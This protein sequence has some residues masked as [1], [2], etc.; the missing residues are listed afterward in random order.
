MNAITLLPDATAATLQASLLAVT[1]EDICR[2]LFRHALERCE[3]VFGSCS[4]RTDVSVDYDLW[5]VAVTIDVDHSSIRSTPSPAARGNSELQT[6]SHL[7]LVQVVTSSSSDETSWIWQDGRQIQSQSVIAALGTSP[8]PFASA[9]ESGRGVTVCM[10]GVFS[11]MPIRRK[12]IASEAAKK[13]SIASLVNCA[14]ELSLL[15]TDSNVR[16]R[17][18]QASPLDGPAPTAK[19]MLSLPR[20]K[21]LVYRYKSAFGADSAQLECVHLIAAE[22]T[23]QSATIKIKGFAAVTAVSDAPRFIFLQRRIWPGPTMCG[24]LP[25]S[26][27]ESAVFASLLS[28]FHL[29]WTEEASNT[30]TRRTTLSPG[31]Y[32]TVCKRIALCRTA[33]DPNGQAF[34]LDI[35]LH[36]SGRA[37]QSRGPRLSV[38]SFE[39]AVLD[40]ICKETPVAHS[41]SPGK[42]KRPSRP[43]TAG[44]CGTK[45]SEVRPVKA[46]PATASLAIESYGPKAA[47]PEGMVEWRNP[48]NGRLFH[49]DQRTGHSVAV[50]PASRMVSDKGT[51]KTVWAPATNRSTAVDRSRLNKGL[52]LSFTKRSAVVD[53]STD[54]DEFD[55][56]GLDEALASI[57]SP[58]QILAPDTFRRSRFF[59]SRLPTSPLKQGH[60]DFV[61]DDGPDPHNAVP[62]R[63]NL[64][65]AITRS[66]LQEA[67][68]LDQVDGKFIVCSTSS[69]GS[70]PNA[71]LFCIDQH[72]ADERYR[73]ER[74]LEQFASDCTE[75]TAAHALP[76]TLTLGISVK[77]CELVRG[78]TTVSEVLKRLGWSV[79]EVVLVHAALGHAQVDLD[80]IPC[81]LKDRV[82]TDRGRVKDQDLLQSAFVNCVEEVVSWPPSLADSTAAEGVDWLAVSRS[83]PTSLMEVV[84][85]TACR[86][87]IMFNDPLSRAAS[88]RVVRRLSECKFPFQCAHGRPSLVPLCEVRTREG[89]SGNLD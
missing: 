43:S 82:L 86:S 14:R 70:A 31:F 11:G 26:E 34:V 12:L 39:A 85:S 2:I 52:Y 13:S 50:G 32:E 49:I 65:L 21:D 24:T 16:L 9:A 22:H 78:S 1:I 41:V 15:A 62:H 19:V 79:K 46:R 67:R 7:G 57:A 20:P 8:S 29:D 77:Q 38:T 61:D 66:D 89:G 30:Y 5:T 48:M 71:I 17:V 74:L 28:T 54:T 33:S 58:S 83:I 4:G 44:Q 59:D 60:V 73:L 18:R 84:K 63:N 37:E 10:S 45:E 40:A 3:D 55:D 25:P 69:S 35:T 75:A 23:F 80:G 36:K 6:I 27:R 64:E 88:E 42:R 51:P 87:A 53:E 76:F 72:A 68:V 47:A 81:I 56:P